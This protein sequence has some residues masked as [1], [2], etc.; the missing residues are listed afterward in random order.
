MPIEFQC[1]NC[2]KPLRTA[3][4]TAGKLAK[5]PKCGAVMT[6]PSPGGD[7]AEPPP[8]V[9]PP[10]AQQSQP[11]YDVS[12]HLSSP[13][14]NAGGTAK[15]RAE[16]GQGGTSGGAS[17]EQPGA[18][19]ASNEAWAGP[20]AETADSTPGRTTGGPATGGPSGGV[21]KP[22]MIDLGDVLTSALNISK[23][24]LGLCVAAVAIAFV[25]VIVAFFSVNFFM[26][27]IFRFLP[28][29]LLY[30]MMQGP[31]I[32]VVVAVVL[33]QCM[34]LF[35]KIAR[36]EPASINELFYIGP[37]TGRVILTY[38]AFMLMCYI[39]SLLCIVPGWILMSVFF[40]VF[41]LAFDRDAS[42]V[43]IFTEAMAMTEGNRLMIFLVLFVAWLIGSAGSLVCGL[44]VLLTMPLALMCQ[45][46]MY[47]R[48]TGG[49]VAVM[50]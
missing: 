23:G 19:W 1:S 17:S 41:F 44:G 40:P 33:A 15:A 8:P 43:D 50:A 18:A 7:V 27:L 10:G 13:A 32:I 29:F 9:S 48:L 11:E 46:V 21:G 38:V 37:D 31:L 20:G 30:G 16:G 42:V 6:I 47:L 25:V 39:G 14:E 4:N 26:G 12:S 49:R 35:L 28:V 22:P 24:Q 45:A 34:R 3:D 2:G 5:C 36:G